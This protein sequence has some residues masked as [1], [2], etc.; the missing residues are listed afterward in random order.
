MPHNPYISKQQL[1]DA[2][3]LADLSDPADGV[4]RMQ[5]LVA[6]AVGAL[7][8]A[9]QTPAIICRGQR[10]VSLCDNYDALGY[11]PD[12][13]A[14]D[15]RY[16]R[17]VDAEHVLRTQTSAAVPAVLR[18]LAP[19]RPTAALIAVPG[20]CWRRDAI[21]RLHVGEPHQLDLWRITTAEQTV[22]DL[23]TMIELV[24]TTPAR[25]ALAGYRGRA[26]LHAGGT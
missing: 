15:A 23:D 17:Y 16:T 8:A 18:A 25:T 10:I 4:H 13:P 11:P 6:D 7:S 26:S 20:L 1:A 14:R 22:S 9:W 3:A 12:G 2:L 21:D 5:Q 19:T 24:V